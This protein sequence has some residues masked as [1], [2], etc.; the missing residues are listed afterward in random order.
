MRSCKIAPDAG[1]K[2]TMNTIAPDDADGVTTSLYCLRIR[3]K[4]WQGS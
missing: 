3:V 4:D 1:K 2:V